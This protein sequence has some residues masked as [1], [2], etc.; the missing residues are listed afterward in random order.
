MSVGEGIFSFGP[1][2]LENVVFGDEV[3]STGMERACEEGGENE[4]IQRVEA[5]IFDEE[6]VE[7]NLDGDVYEVN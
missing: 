6:D 4:V 1:E 5:R 7:E 3:S 2:L